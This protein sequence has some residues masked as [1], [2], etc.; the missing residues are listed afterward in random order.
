MPMSTPSHPP[1]VD[2]SGAVV[3][4]AGRTVLRG[5]DLHVRQGEFV[6]LLGANGS[7]K[8]TLVRTVVGLVPRRAGQVALFGTPLESFRSWRRLGYVPQRLT[9]TSGVPATVAEVVAEG[10]LSRGAPFRRVSRADRAAVTAALEAVGMADRARDSLTRLSGGQQQ[11]VLIAR[12][13]AGEPE[14]LILDEPTAGVDVPSQQAFAEL[15][16]RLAGGGTTVLLVAHELGPL[17]PLVQRAV[18]LRHGR[19]VHDGAPPVA[20]DGALHVHHAD[21]QAGGLLT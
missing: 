12:A 4:L 11:R 10:R 17:Q 8:S 6:A 14:A 5:V 20:L 15:L 9:A 21:E 1:V 7:G 16:E 2:V 19:V 18:V 3:A 13:L